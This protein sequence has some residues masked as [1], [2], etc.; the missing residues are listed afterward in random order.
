MSPINAPA[1]RLDCRLL[2]AV[3]MFAAMV[4]AAAVF[5]WPLLPAASGAGL[6]AAQEK[7]QEAP[8]EEPPRVVL[9]IDYGDGVEKRFKALEWKPGLT[10]L[11]ALEQASRHRRGI[12]LQYRGSGATAFVLQI[13]DLENEGGGGKNW[14]Y[15]VN[16]QP[17]KRGAGVLALEAGDEVLWTFG[18]LR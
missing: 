11:E 6:A 14:L 7:A 3:T 18:P 9:T 1:R 5:A 17:A 8:A 15:R 16:G 10:A 13:D 2:L 4:L 12:K